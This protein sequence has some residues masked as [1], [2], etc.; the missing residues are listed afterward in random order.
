MKNGWRGYWQIPPSNSYA[1]MII[2]ARGFK[3][4]RFV[5]LYRPFCSNQAALS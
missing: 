2:D 5:G 4:A 1:P 3:S